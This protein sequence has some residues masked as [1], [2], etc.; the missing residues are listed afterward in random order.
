MPSPA[1]MGWRSPAA[2][3]LAAGQACRPG[4]CCLRDTSCV[5]VLPPS[6]TSLPPASPSLR[7]EGRSSQ[8]RAPCGKKASQEAVDLGHLA[9]PSA[10]LGVGGLGKGHAFALCDR[11]PTS[12]TSCPR[13]SSVALSSVPHMPRGPCCLADPSAWKVLSQHSLPLASGSIGLLSLR[14][15]RFKCHLHREVL[16]ASSPQ[17]ACPVPPTPIPPG[18]LRQAQRLPFAEHFRF[19]LFAAFR[20]LVVCFRL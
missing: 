3:R 9:P 19:Q 18:T 11:V 1:R 5:R 2:T 13:G 16:G 7:R 8:R 20:L 12:L 17:E 4:R 15:S 14:G 6:Q 10:H